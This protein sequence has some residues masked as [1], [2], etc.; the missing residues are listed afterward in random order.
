MAQICETVTAGDMAGLRR[1]RDAASEA[2]LVEL[3]LD[4]VRDVDVAGAL[5]GRARPVIVTCRAAW[6]GG[7]FDGSEDERLSILS[8]AVRLGAEF[9]DV[10]WRADWQRLPLPEGARLVLS[11]HDFDGVPSDLAS[12]VRAM[13]SA[14]PGMIK[15]A[16]TATNAAD[17]LALR[18]V[19]AGGTNQVMIAMGP[20]G[21]I[22]RCCP[23]FWGSRWTYGGSAAPGQTPVRDLARRYRVRETSAGTA[24]FALTGTPLAHSASPAMHNA[25]LAATRLN[26]V[27]VPVEATSAADFLAVADGLGIA[28]ASVTAP[29][30]TGWAQL[31][32]RVDRTAA[33]AGAVNSLRRGMA[34]GWD[35]TNFDAAGF[36]APLDARHI[37]LQGRRVVVLGAGGAA[38]AVVWALRGRGARI[39]ISARRPEAAAQLAEAMAVSVSAWPP[40]PGWDVLVNATSAGTW[41]D[42]AAAPVPRQALGGGL[43]YDLVYNPAD[44][45]LLEWARATGA[46]TIGGLEMLVEQAA[47]QFAWW[48]GVPAPREIM[49]QA[50]AAFL[51]R[52]TV[53]SDEADH[54]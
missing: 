44:T 39:E 46:D 8:R 32:V 52:Q 16:I 47:Q 28:G 49:R 41:P 10:E 13:R 50:A 30:K 15:V 21:V 2:D 48:T 35:G 19:A 20:A 38:R 34:G 14:S 3:R 40:V 27:Y 36:L 9:V 42:V 22:T 51:G 11:E 54:V 24:V 18:D 26:A 25:A 33:A 12:R 4:G 43:V 6:A 45:R 5:E 17:C 29:F 37:A 1:R 31:G 53:R 23:W 7:R